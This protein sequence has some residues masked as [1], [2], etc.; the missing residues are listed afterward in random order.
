MVPPRCQYLIAI[1]VAFVI[2]ITLIWIVYVMFTRGYGV[3]EKTLIKSMIEKEGAALKAAE[4]FQNMSEN[5]VFKEF[6]RT[7]LQRHEGIINQLKDFL[8][9]IENKK[10]EENKKEAE[11]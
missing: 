4:R 2:V 5:P 11:I 6:G 9:I 8:T 7:H 10:E 3:T 1:F